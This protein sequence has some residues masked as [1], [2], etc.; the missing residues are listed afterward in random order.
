MMLLTL[1]AFVAAA[2][3]LKRLTYNSPH[4]VVVVQ[5]PAFTAERSAQF[6]TFS[7]FL[8]EHCNGANKEVKGAWDSYGWST[9]VD[10]PPQPA[11]VGMELGLGDLLISLDA[12]NCKEPLFSG[13]AYKT[14][15]T[16]SLGQLPVWDLW[17]GH[18]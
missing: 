5:P 1:L 12:P 16:S 6:Y 9:D 14:N 2:A 7:V 3:A 15:F 11:V 13:A 17:L 10:I 8:N 18:E 4:T